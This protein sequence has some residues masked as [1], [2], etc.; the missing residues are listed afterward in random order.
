[1]KKLEINTLWGW[2]VLPVVML[3]MGLGLIWLFGGCGHVEK[4]VD[5]T[6]VIVGSAYSVVAPAV[7]TVAITLTDY[8]GS[9]L[10]FK[11]WLDGDSVKTDADSTVYSMWGDRWWKCFGHCF[12]V[13]GDRVGTA[14]SKCIASCTAGCTIGDAIVAVTCDWFGDRK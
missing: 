4:I 10:K 14:Y 6:K 11:A 13:C 5:N 2:L 8:Y 7:D 1:M 12:D 9:E 3:A